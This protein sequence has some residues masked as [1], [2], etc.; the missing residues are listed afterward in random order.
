M[1]A[2]KFRYQSRP[3]QDGKGVNISR[4]HDFSGR[5]LDPF[6]MLDEIRSDNPDDYV[7]GFPPHPH[8]G[9]ETFTYMRKGGFEHRDALG[10]RA[11]VGPGGVQWMKSGKGMLHSEMPL[12][13]SQLGLH[14]FQIWIN[15]SATQKMKAPQYKDSEAI[16]PTMLNEGAV[17]FLLGGN[18]QLPDITLQSSIQPN[19]GQASIADLALAPDTI[20][21]FPPQGEP[22]LAAYVYEGSLATP[23]A[24]PGMLMVLDGE[25][26]IE[27]QSGAQGARLLLLKG[28]PHNEP[29]AH[30]G[31]F[32]MNTQEEIEQALQDFRSGQF[33]HMEGE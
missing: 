18:W 22:M 4:V 28:Q 23:D 30:Y 16:T 29:I 24:S 20:T 32:V 2:V 33:G 27:L 25:N 12:P 14:G 3:T 6:L 13:D 5:W 8:R 26:G 17:L 7:G 19:E 21:C 11:A 10:N 9:I 1:P 31:P 15:Q